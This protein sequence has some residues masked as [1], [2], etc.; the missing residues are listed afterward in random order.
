MSTTIIKI[1]TEYSDEITKD[2][3]TKAITRECQLSAAM[4]KKYQAKLA[5]YEEEYNLTYH[6]I[7]QLIN[8]NDRTIWTVYNRA[9][10]KK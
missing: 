2:M 8:R 3:V 7:G 10:K 9:K 5:R 1:H 6:Q 4:V